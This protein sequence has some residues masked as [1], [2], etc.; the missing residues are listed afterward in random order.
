MIQCRSAYRMAD[1]ELTVFWLSAVSAT[2]TKDTSEPLMTNEPENSAT[3]TRRGFVVQAATVFIS[4]VLLLVPLI[5]GLIVFLDP[6]LRRQKS[7]LG[8]F[9]RVGK[10]SECP[11]DTTPVQFQVVGQQQDAWNTSVG[12]LGSVYV[13]RKAPGSDELVVLHATCPHLG[14]FVNLSG[15]GFKCPCHNSSFQPDGSIVAGQC[16]SPRPMDTLDYEIRDGEIWIKF[17]NFRS[18]T[19]QKIPLGA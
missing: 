11:L 9:Y 5:S 4:S 2:D 17:Q 19:E 1:G 16:V 3:P 14:C 8:E 15:N 18:N 13:R 7:G 10:L 6:L 12:P